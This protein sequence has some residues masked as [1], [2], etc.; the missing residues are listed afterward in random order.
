MRVGM[1]ATSSHAK[2]FDFLARILVYSSKQHSHSELNG[3][4]SWKCIDWRFIQRPLL[5]DQLSNSDT[6]PG[7]DS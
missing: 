7:C 4:Q 3:I 2:H 1:V 5:F 6:E